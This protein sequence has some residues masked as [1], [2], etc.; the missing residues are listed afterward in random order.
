MALG[1]DLHRQFQQLRDEHEL[2]RQR[3]ATSHEQEHATSTRKACE[4]LSTTRPEPHDKDVGAENV[5]RAF[6]IL[7]EDAVSHN[8]PRS[9]GTSSGQLLPDPSS[10]AAAG[11]GCIAT[12]ASL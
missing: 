8:R 4:W 10:T 6:A 1:T 7:H 11:T 5:R 12:T 2:L 3:D 9:G